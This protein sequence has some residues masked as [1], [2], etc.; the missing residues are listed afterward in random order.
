MNLRPY[1][2]L[3]CAVHCRK[4]A[5]NVIQKDLAVIQ[6]SSGL[7]L[8]LSF[9]AASWGWC[10]DGTDSVN[11]ECCTYPLTSLLPF[12]S[13][14]MC[15]FPVFGLD[16]WFMTSFVTWK[17]SDYPSWSSQ[18]CGVG[19]LQ[20]QGSQLLT[21]SNRHIV[22]ILCYNYRGKLGVIPQHYF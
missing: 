21:I 10:I 4:C 1:L 15:C 9:E 14:F 20:T 11:V 19:G 18:C 8:R 17:V 3:L 16:F 5:N 12:L 22:Y 2:K 7:L 13:M 6:Y